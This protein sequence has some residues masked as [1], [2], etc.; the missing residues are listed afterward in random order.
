MFIYWLNIIFIFIN[1]MNKGEVDCLFVGSDHAGFQ[2]K[3]E[4]LVYFTRMYPSK[5]I[6]NLG[7]F[8]E[9]NSDYPDIVK[10]FKKGLSKLKKTVDYDHPLAILIG[11]TGIGMAIAANKIKPVRAAACN[12]IDSVFS[13]VLHNNINVL[14]I[15]K[16]SEH[17]MINVVEGFLK[18]EFENLPIHQQRIKKIHKI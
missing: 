16:L 10:E 17:T 18:L 7:V 15:G 13:A 1:K 5:V 9:V 8:S 14:C 3:E 11:A 4:L 12:D 2:L 6:I